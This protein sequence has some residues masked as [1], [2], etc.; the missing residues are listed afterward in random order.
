MLSGVVSCTVVC[1]VVIPIASVAPSPAIMTDPTVSIKIVLRSIYCM[2]PNA[3]NNNAYVPVA[4]ST[5][6]PFDL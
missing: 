5:N 1:L 2:D 6:I 4:Y 3:N